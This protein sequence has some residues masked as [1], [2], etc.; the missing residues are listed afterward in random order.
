MV[1]Y[2][3]EIDYMK[4][5][6]KKQTTLDLAADPHTLIVQAGKTLEERAMTISALPNATEVSGSD[7]GHY[8]KRLAIKKKKLMQKKSNP[9]WPFEKK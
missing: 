7:I 3:R 8:F 4:K 9:K 5:K 2:E 1:T 6:L